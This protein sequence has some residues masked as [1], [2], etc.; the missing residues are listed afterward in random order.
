MKKLAAVLVALIMAAGVVSCTP[1]PNDAT[2]VAEDFLAAL[3]TNDA[4]SI[5]PLI[6]DSTTATE[7][8]NATYTGLQA[9]G[10]TATLNQVEQDENMAT[11]SYTLQWQLP[12]ERELT[13]DTQLTLTQVSG[14]WSVRWQPSLVHPA[15]GAHQHLELRPVQAEPASVISSDGAELLK[16]G[17][18]YRLLVNTEQMESSQSTARAISDALNAAH[19]DDRTV[20]QRD[21][22]QLAE[23]ISRAQGTYSV[24]MVPQAQGQRVKD[25]LADVQGV[26]INEEAAMVNE[27]P[28]FAPDIMAR[29]GGIVADELEGTNGWRVSIVNS[30][31]AAYEDVEYHGPDPAPAVKISLDS[32]VQTA[33]EQALEPVAGQQAVI[34]A[35]RPSSGEILAIAQTQ[36]ADRDGNIG[37]MG[38]YPPGSVFKIVTAAAG[39]ELQ[40]Q[41]PGSIVGCPG[42]QNIYGRI[43]TNYEGFALGNVPLEEAFARSCNTT[44]ADM[45]TNLEPGELEKVGKQF[46]LGVDYNIPGLDTLTGSIPVGETPL[47][48]TEAGYGQGYDLA[49]PFGLALV[50]S[51]VANG[52]TPTPYLIEGQHTEVSEEVAPLSEETITNTRQMMRSVVTN[53]TASGMTAGG[54]IYGKTG[55][56]EITGGSHAWFAGYRDDLAFATLV[57]LGGGSEAAVALTD[58][59]LVN[60]DQ[61]NLPPG[62]AAHEPGG[63]LP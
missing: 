29:V 25:A 21:A 30:E 28:S 11:A 18:A 8:I 6:D 59:M 57:V 58:S 34:V 61:A 13:Y 51:T 14:Q 7:V 52:Q 3:T 2:P 4:E 40:G 41:T 56:A 20:P 22:A 46:G 55:E 42:T 53:G 27:D 33:A 50:A 60:L 1:R 32:K 16:P 44:F 35:V 62:D 17:V 37:L 63:G 19:N 43:V 26:V 9:E 47:E 39:L 45:S 24:A 10:A 12:R 5:A 38:Q 49:S 48:R 31:G 23:E 54:E 15:L 36:A